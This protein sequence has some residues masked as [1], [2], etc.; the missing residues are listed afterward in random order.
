M[1]VTLADPSCQEI[2]ER[3]HFENPIKCIE[4]AIHSDLCKYIWHKLLNCPIESC[5]YF[6]QIQYH[7]EGNS[8]IFFVEDQIAAD[9][10]YSL[11][12]QITL[13]DGFKV[14]KELYT[15]SRNDITWTL[16]FIWQLQ[17]SVRASPA[18]NLPINEELKTKIQQVMSRRY[19]PLTKILN[20]SQFHLDEGS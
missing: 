14:I 4:N 2:R 7:T 11:N 1:V 20:L 13:A 9:A 18:P 6:H 16:Q 3:S 10:L 15:I 12:R 8:A 19:D 17:I 5:Y